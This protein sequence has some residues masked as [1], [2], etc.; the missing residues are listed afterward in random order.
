MSRNI[1]WD[2]C[3]YGGEKTRIIC[4]KKGPPWLLED[5]PRL[6]A[7]PHHQ[8]PIL[9]LSELHNGGVKFSLFMKFHLT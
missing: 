1:A 9:P 8:P 7:Q 6:A 2:S 4:P 5:A 3:K